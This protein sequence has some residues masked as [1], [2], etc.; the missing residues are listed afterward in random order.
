MLNPPENKKTPL[1]LWIAAV[2]IALF[3]FISWL[4]TVITDKLYFTFFA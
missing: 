2:F 3:F 1:L 4:L